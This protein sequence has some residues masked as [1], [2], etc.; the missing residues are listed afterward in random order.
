MNLLQ[1]FNSTDC[2]PFR[3]IFLSNFQHIQAENTDATTDGIAATRWKY[4]RQLHQ[5]LRILREAIAVERLQFPLRSPADLR[6]CVALI[7]D[8]V[9]S[10]MCEDNCPEGS[11]DL[12]TETELQSIESTG[13][14]RSCVTET[15]S[16]GLSVDSATPSNDPTVHSEH[17]QLLST[18]DLHLK[19]LK[20]SR[21]H[22]NCIPLGAVRV[23]G[24]FERS[25][26]F[27]VLADRVG[28]PCGLQL[29]PVCPLMAWN[30]V[31]QPNANADVVVATHIVNL[32]LPPLGCLLA[33]GTQIAQDY[34]QPCA[35]DRQ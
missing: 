18:V 17:T 2:S 33:I 30:V 24:Y 6:R 29:S 28:L 20:H 5:R 10:R 26:L 9:C 1:I 19:K 3:T 13:T 16:D 31:A 14:F 11:I 27:K 4:D 25:L 8:V 23:G 32:M 12:E 7:S 21:F 34:Q 15:E 35:P 22:D